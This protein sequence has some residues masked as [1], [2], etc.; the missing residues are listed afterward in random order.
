LTFESDVKIT[1]VTIYASQYD[2]AVSIK[3]N[4][5]TAQ[6]VTNATGNAYIGYEFDVDNLNE[7]TVSSV[8]TSKTRVQIQKIV[9]EY[10]PN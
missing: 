10:S 4:E 6:V 7:F 5:L 3:V 9:I 2:G 1:K 8:K